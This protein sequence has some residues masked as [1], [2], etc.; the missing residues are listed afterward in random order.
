[1]RC[2]LLRAHTRKER[3]TAVSSR[4]VTQQPAP[5]P[6]PGSGPR[7]RP[8]RAPGTVNPGPSAGRARGLGLGDPDRPGPGAGRPGPGPYWPGLLHRRLPPGWAASAGEQRRGA[9]AWHASGLRLLPLRPASHHPSRSLPRVQLATGM[10][11][12]HRHSESPDLPLSSPQATGKAAA[13][14]MLAC[15]LAGPLLEDVTAQ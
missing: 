9:R 6:G 13:R 11:K 14:L 10:A 2:S 12:C 4:S 15:S 7:P 8:G 3:G 1:M 5:G